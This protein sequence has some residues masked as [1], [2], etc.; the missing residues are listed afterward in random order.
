MNFSSF[1][2]ISLNLSAYLCSPLNFFA[3][4]YMNLHF[5]VFLFISLYF[6]AFCSISLYFSAFPFILRFILRQ[7]DGAHRRPMDAIFFIYVHAAFMI[8]VPI[9]I[10]AAAIFYLHACSFYDWVPI[11]IILTGLCFSCW[12]DAI[13]MI[14]CDMNGMMI[15][16]WL[17][18][19][20]GSHLSRVIWF[21]IR[22]WKTC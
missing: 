13:G 16:N 17:L 11:T 9:T 20:Y 12:Y 3:F 7:F 19:G 2:C 14:W 18:L 5:S 22:L 4:L 15:L 1:L 8:G 21:R 10:S 6:F